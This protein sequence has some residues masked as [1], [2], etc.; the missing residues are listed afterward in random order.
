MELVSDN[1]GDVW[2]VLSAQKE[3]CMLDSPSIGAAQE[4][5][6]PLAWYVVFYH[7]TRKVFET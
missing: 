4:H 6:S 1:F 2:F 3:F 7:S 5:L